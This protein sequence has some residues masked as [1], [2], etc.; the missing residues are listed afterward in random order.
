MDAFVEYIYT[1]Y[2]LLNIDTCMPQ[3]CVYHVILIECI[4]HKNKLTIL[5]LKHTLHTFN[6]SHHHTS[7]G[8]ISLLTNFSLLKF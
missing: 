1:K 5:I 7:L 2:K 3:A 8:Y 4:P 6:Q